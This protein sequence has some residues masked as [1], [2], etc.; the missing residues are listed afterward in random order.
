MPYLSKK[1]ESLISGYIKP[2]ENAEAA[3]LREVKKNLD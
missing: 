2:G 3:A 1:Y